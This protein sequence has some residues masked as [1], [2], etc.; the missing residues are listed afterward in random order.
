MT[1][2]SGALRGMPR[3]APR[4]QVGAHGRRT[5]VG[6]RS[7]DRMREEAVWA[8]RAARGDRESFDLLFDHYARL[9]CFFRDRPRDEAHAAIWQALE[10]IFLGLESAEDVAVRAYRI[11]RH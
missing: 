11:A 6:A 1:R 9:A 4:A 2:Q 8:Y 3:P 10:Q 7:S 5:S